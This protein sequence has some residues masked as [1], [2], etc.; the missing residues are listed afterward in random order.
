MHFDGYLRM[1]LV[2]NL[3][4]CIAP[5]GIA[6]IHMGQDFVYVCIMIVNYTLPFICNI[7]AQYIIHHTRAPLRIICYPYYIFRCIIFNTSPPWRCV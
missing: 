4:I 6:N 7:L 5:V 1:N 3:K 2:A